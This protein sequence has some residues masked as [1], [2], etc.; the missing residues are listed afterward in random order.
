VTGE[1]LAGTFT[2]AWGAS[3]PAS[4][5][6][7]R[8]AVSSWLAWCAKNRWSAPELPAVLE[9]RPEHAD[10]TKALPRVAIQRQLSRRDVPLREKTLWRM[11]YSIPVANAEFA[12]N[13]Y[14]RAGRSLP[15]IF[16]RRALRIPVEA[17]EQCKR[18]RS[19]I[20]RWKLPVGPTRASSPSAQ[21]RQPRL[22]RHRLKK[23]EVESEQ[24]NTTRTSG[25]A[26]AQQRRDRQRPQRTPG[27]FLKS[28][29]RGEG[30]KRLALRA[31]RNVNG[32]CG[33]ANSGQFQYGA[34]GGDI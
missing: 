3:A 32:A 18:R 24:A 12:T 13:I 23:P 19:M 21:P 26:L 29:P 8:A 14:V 9:R 1:E 6:R 17:S 33:G 7:N 31:P 10:H 20:F 30:A 16:A 22:N 28:I 25:N 5:N 34:G 2:A 4:W 11:L 27:L 15:T